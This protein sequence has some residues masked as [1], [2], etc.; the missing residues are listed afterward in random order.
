MKLTITLPTG[1]KLLAVAAAAVAVL[2]LLLCVFAGVRFFRAALA[3][4]GQDDAAKVKSLENEVVLLNEKLSTV[5]QQ[6][7]TLCEQLDAV[8]SDP[9]KLAE[10][11]SQLET[12]QTEILALQEDAQIL[13]DALTGL[14]SEKGKLLADLEALEGTINAVVNSCS[15]RYV[16]TV[17]IVQDMVLWTSDT[18]I[19]YQAYV[20]ADEYDMIQPGTILTSC[21]GLDVPTTGGYQ[22]L[23][24][25]KYIA[26][27]SQYGI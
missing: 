25:S 26:D 11:E 6:A 7:N 18:G 9:Q 19:R 12:K 21:P 24:V 4:G 16:V 10:L 20:T 23:V 17:K 13:R 1:R 5:T 27:L 8:D 14:E 15:K 2:L 3:L 22:I